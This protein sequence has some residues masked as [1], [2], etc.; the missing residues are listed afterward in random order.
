MDAVTVNGVC[1]ETA[2]RI[3]RNASDADDYVRIRVA[4]SGG[5]AV[6]AA[7]EKRAQIGPDVWGPKANF[8]QRLKIPPG[9][10]LQIICGTTDRVAEEQQSSGLDCNF[11]W[12]I[13]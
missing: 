12:E 10:I 8:V 9:G 5:C 11:E 13:L 6:F 7:D 1:E 3:Y 2:T 4:N